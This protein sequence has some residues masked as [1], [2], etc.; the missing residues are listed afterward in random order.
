M[1][2]WIGDRKPPRSVGHDQC[3]RTVYLRRDGKVGYSV[4]CGER[5][6]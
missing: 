6:G 5:I 1:I 3:N 4:L 2:I